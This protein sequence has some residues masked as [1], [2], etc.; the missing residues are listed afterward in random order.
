MPLLPKFLLTVATLFAVNTS[1][2]FLSRKECLFLFAPRAFRGWLVLPYVRPSVRDPCVHTFLSSGQCLA[3]L[4]AFS[5]FFAA[6]SLVE[7]AVVLIDEPS[8]DRARA[9]PIDDMKEELSTVAPEPASV[10]ASF[11]FNMFFEVGSSA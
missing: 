10:E 6:F 11:D 9:M 5:L 8:W 4:F 3:K 2:G 1:L 7:H